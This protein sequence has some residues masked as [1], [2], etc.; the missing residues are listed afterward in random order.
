MPRSFAI[1]ELVRFVEGGWPF[2]D[3]HAV[4]IED[5]RE[6]DNYV[7]RAELPGMD[8]EKD[9][10]IS[11]QGNE[12]SITAE[13]SVAKHDKAHSEFS[14][15]SFARVVR[16]PAGAIAEDVA[17]TYDAGILQVTVPI[18]PAADARQIEVKATK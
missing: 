14:Y 1:P 6:D 17:A 18:K 5:Y 10:R 16:L 11:V 9:I 4:R 2:G 8:P 13:R 3:H 7:L 15:G 12:L